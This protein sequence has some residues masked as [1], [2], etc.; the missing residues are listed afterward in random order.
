MA[1]A[2]ASVHMPSLSWR[3]PPP[4]VQSFFTVRA[5]PLVRLSSIAKLFDFRT[6][7]WAQ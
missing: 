3:T 4:S 2:Q 5:G 7:H 6:F 1:N